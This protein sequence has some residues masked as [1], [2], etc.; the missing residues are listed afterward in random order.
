MSERNVFVPP[1]HVSSEQ[2]VIFLAGPIQGASDWQSYAINILTTLKPNIC[3]ASP[4]REKFEG[5]NYDEQVDW[6]TENLRKA[7][8]NGV[9]MFW[10]AKESEQIQERSYAQTSRAEL[11]E[12]K[13]RH[14]RDGAKIVIGIEEGFS[15][16]KYIRR[17][18]GQDCPDVPILDSLEETCKKALET[19]ES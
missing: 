19:I 1:E 2:R 4:R 12:W 14:E 3:I 10:L 5:V 17:R 15:G 8:K 11:F 16:S 7:G 6:E 18:F 9:I 13:V